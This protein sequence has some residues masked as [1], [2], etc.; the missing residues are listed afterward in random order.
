MGMGQ[1]PQLVLRREPDSLLVEQ[2]WTQANLAHGCQRQES[3][4]YQQKPGQRLG[5]SLDEGHPTTPNTNA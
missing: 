1:A 5:P 3:T 4:Q 2:G